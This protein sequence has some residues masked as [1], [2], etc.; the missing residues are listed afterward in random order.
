MAP[1]FK[2]ENSQ[3]TQQK[4][5][6]L[7]HGQNTVLFISILRRW[8]RGW[9]RGQGGGLQLSSDHNH[10]FSLCRVLLTLRQGTI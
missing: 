7:S 2:F 10:L 6:K 8:G 1:F 4:D 9:G 3:M 5:V